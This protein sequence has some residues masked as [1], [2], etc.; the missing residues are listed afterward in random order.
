MSGP[1]GG[2]GGGGG[3][4]VFLAPQDEW[5][6]DGGVEGIDAAHTVGGPT[7]WTSPNLAGAPNILPAAVTTP[8]NELR[9]VG[10][11]GTSGSGDFS[12]AMRPLTLAIDD[13]VLIRAQV[14]PRIALGLG[15]GGIGTGYVAQFHVGV[16]ANATRNETAGLGWYGAGVQLATQTYL[17]AQTTIGVQGQ[18]GF[19]SAGLPGLGTGP[20]GSAA[21][22][23]TPIDSWM[24]VRQKRVGQ[25]I[26]QW[27]R[28]PGGPWILCSSADPTANFYNYA[29]HAATAQVLLRMRTGSLNYVPIFRVYAYKHFAGGLPAQY[30]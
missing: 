5:V 2:G 28:I 26:A 24:D 4:S 3:G 1:S 10:V 16:S 19:P 15:A 20:S 12:V 27:I 22:A 21:T 9:F 13:E 14:E 29:T 30:Q 7:G 8:G 25:W 6:F 17:N 18:A 11:A 23:E